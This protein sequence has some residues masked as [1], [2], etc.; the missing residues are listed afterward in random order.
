MKKALIALNLLLLV[1]IL[2]LACKND[3]AEPTA[4]EKIHAKS[5]EGQE[6]DGYLSV[7]Q[8]KEI[9]DAYDADVEK[10]YISMGGKM[11]NVPDAHRVWMSI[12]KLKQYI[13]QME[14]V[15]CKQGCDLDSMGLGLHFYLAKYPDSSKIKEYGVPAV[16]ANHQTI[17]IT[18]TYKGK[19]A[20]VDFDPFNVGPEKCKPTPLSELLKNPKSNGGPIKAGEGGGVL[21]HGTLAPPPDGAGGFPSTDGD[22]TSSK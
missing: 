22:G 4:C 13:W 18:A 6:M 1:I 8:A 5:Y 15:L 12:D 16:Y 11:T 19:T 21:N 17:F 9:S 14:E 7:A 3:K 10:A 2:F 20:N